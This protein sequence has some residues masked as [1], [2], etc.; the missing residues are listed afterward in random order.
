MHLRRYSVRAPLLRP[1]ACRR[2]ETRS[3]LCRPLAQA[4]ESFEIFVVAFGESPPLS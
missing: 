4:F 1:E 2:A 3:L